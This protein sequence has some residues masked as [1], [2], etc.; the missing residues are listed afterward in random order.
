MR[1]QRTSNLYREYCRQAVETSRRL[2]EKMGP[3][4]AE[5]LPDVEATWHAVITAPAHERIAASHLIARGFGI[6]LPEA[7]DV[8]IKRGRTVKRCKPLIPGY[9]FVYVWDIARHARRIRACTGVL[10]FLLADG[11]IMTIPWKIIDQLRVIENY[12]RPIVLPMD[13]VVRPKQAKKK[14]WRKSRAEPGLLAVPAE[15]IGVHA[16]SP[17]IEEM[18]KD[19]DDENRIAVFRRAL[20]LAGS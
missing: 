17:F 5:V 9:L 14:R 11:R 18:R 3:Y 16:Y 10:D 1:W 15:I 7:E 2:D 6:Y 4:S 19:L 12:E 13:E 20:G 8:E